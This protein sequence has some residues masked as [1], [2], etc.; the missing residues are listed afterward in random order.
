[1]LWTEQGNR[2][3]AAQKDYDQSPVEQLSEGQA[4]DGA[5]SY[6]SIAAKNQRGRLRDM[7]VKP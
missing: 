3:Q 5:N 2:G 7:T 1:M 6:T 4:D